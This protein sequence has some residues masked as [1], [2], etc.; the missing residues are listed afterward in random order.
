MKLIDYIRSDRRGKEANLLEREAMND[1]FLMDAIEGYDTVYGDHY[2]MLQRLEVWV[3]D[4]ARMRK[5]ARRRKLW[6]GVAAAAVVLVGAGT[7]LY[8]YTRFEPMDVPVAELLK[9]ENDKVYISEYEF[10]REMP[11]DMAVVAQARTGDTAEAVKEARAAVS[12]AAERFSDAAGTDM[13]IVAIQ[14]AGSEMAEEVIRPAA[15]KEAAARKTDAAG[16]AVAEEAATEAAA[17]VVADPIPVRD[18]LATR[19]V[20]S[21]EHA[22]TVYYEDFAKYFLENRKPKF[23]ASGNRQKGRVTLE[24]RV[25]TAGVPSAIHVISS[26]SREANREAIEML[27]EGPRWEPTHDRRIRT[28]VEYE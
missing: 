20:S 26:F 12:P 25:N 3:D 18:V 27:V 11:A 7:A 8:L 10:R 1:P 21:D 4:H 28:V 5:Q 15:V 14:A 23:D 6:G 19:T 24:F 22:D 13:E 2:D 17:L 9:G 16:K